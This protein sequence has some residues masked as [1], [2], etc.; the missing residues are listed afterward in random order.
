MNGLGNDPDLSCALARDVT[1]Q[2]MR[3]R[4]GCPILNL[5]GHYPNAFLRF[6]KNFESGNF[7]VF[8]ILGFTENVV[9]EN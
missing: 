4:R 1:P 8:R 2:A 9:L 7:Q 5:L 6:P 3:L